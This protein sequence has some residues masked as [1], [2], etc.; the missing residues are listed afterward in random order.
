MSTPERI[1]ITGSSGYYGRA[2]VHDIRRC[3]PEA[4]IL[5][6]DVVAPRSDEPHEFRRCDI[7][8]PEIRE[9]VRQFQPDTILHFAFVVNPM[10]D[11]NRM[12]QINVG[13]SR[14]ILE[15]AAEVKPRR[16][17]VS[18]SATAYGAWPDNPIPMTEDSPLRTRPNF[19]YADD[20]YQVEQL[21]KQF[22]NDHPNMAVSW[23]RP[24]IIYGNGVSNFMMPL[25]TATSLL[26]L[27]GGSNPEMQF[28]HLEDVSG[29]TIRILEANARG[30]FNVAPPD[31]FTIRDLG[32]LSRRPVIPVPDVLCRTTTKVWWALRLP[33]FRFPATLWDF[34]RYPWVVSPARIQNELGYQFRYSSLDVMR[35]LLKDT[36]RLK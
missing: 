36:G 31:T 11:E 1:L 22:S 33:L 20:K 9:I 4:K 35:M 7:T 23:T 29:A 3:W 2:V 28:V 21:L 34:I 19:R 26:V 16:L 6:L 17:L 25:F 32:K 24:C 15:A 27:A 10:R 8:S 30:P 13:G 18:S 14:T 12:H 5:G